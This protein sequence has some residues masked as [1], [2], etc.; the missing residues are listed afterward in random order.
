MNP[1]QESLALVAAPVKLAESGDP[2]TLTAATLRDAFS[3]MAGGVAVLAAGEPGRVRGVT[4]T[5]FVGLSLSPALAGFACDGRSRMLAT[6][7]P[8]DVV[9]MT[10]L[11]EDQQDVARCCA[12]PERGALPESALTREVLGIP[13]ISGGVARF[14]LRLAS[15][16][17]AGDHT[18]VIAEVLDA[19]SIGG[20]PL[21]YHHRHYGRLERPWPQ[22]QSR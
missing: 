9:G 22:G 11:A 16:Q 14:S 4:L 15:R 6:L 7:S 5:S 2:R 3:R 13:F 1:V 21:I 17:P 10:M 20:A 8:G 18:L 19:A 12:A